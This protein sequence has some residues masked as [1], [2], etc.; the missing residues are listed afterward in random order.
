MKSYN[1]A[2]GFALIER[3]EVEGLKVAGQENDATAIMSG[4]VA[5]GYNYEG[6][7][8]VIFIRG[9]ARELVLSNKKYYIIKEDK[10][11]IHV[12]DDS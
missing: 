1:A 2:N 8:E 9:D 7:E 12:E 4:I 3:I 11:L 5:S 10:I 6:G